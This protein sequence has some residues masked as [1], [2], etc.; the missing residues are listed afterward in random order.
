MTEG[1]RR[2][3]C[4][5]LRPS[6][7][8]E[9]PQS[10]R[11]AGRLHHTLHGA[12]DP[13]KR[14]RER[15]AP[16]LCSCPQHTPRGAQ[17]GGGAHRPGAMA[18]AECRWQR[19]ALGWWDGSLE[20]MHLTAARLEHCG[21]WLEGA[22]GTPEFGGCLGLRKFSKIEVWKVRDASEVTEPAGGRAVLEPLCALNLA[23]WRRWAGA[24]GRR[25]R[26][27]F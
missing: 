27:T 11:I 18:G 20:V 8:S 1:Y 10:G 9:L 3:L 2:R 4:P 24:G 14:Q 26:C 5:F 16:L 23:C 13:A 7:E 15:W 21:F 17:T 19:P 22:Q 12:G 25:G 6:Q